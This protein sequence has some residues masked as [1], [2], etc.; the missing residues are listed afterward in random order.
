LFKPE[1]ESKPHLNSL[2]A[3]VKDFSDKKI[4]EQDGKIRIMHE[5]SLATDII[6]IVKSSVPP[7]ELHEIES[8]LVDI[9]DFAGV[10][11]DS[12]VF[13]F[14]AITQSTPLEGA[15]LEINHI[16]YLIKCNNCGEESTNEFGLAICTP[17][18]S[19]DTVLISGNE[20]KVKEVKLREN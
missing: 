7:E 11:T 3:P 20:L 19:T 10:V 13:S 1:Q 4:F 14:G 17:C 15:R 8:I 2:P 18:G 9:G 6:D 5:L 16:P 12:L